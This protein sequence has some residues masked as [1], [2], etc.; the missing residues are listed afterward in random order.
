[1]RRPYFTLERLDEL[2]CALSDNDAARQLD[3]ARNN[4]SSPSTTPR[5]RPPEG[6]TGGAADLPQCP[7]FRLI[8]GLE[9]THPPRPPAGT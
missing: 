4:S 1:M 8:S 6:S 9:R 5:Q 3:E 7:P 2:A